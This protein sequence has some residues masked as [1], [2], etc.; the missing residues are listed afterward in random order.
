MI[1]FQISP[2][3]VETPGDHQ[4]PLDEVA[5]DQVSTRVEP[6]IRQCRIIR[7][8]I[9]LSGNKKPDIRQYPASHAG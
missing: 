6:D 7:P 4:L 3:L 2:T 5:Q 9:R 8:D 1:D